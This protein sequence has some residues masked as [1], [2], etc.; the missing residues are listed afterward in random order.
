M[1]VK[2]GIN[3]LGRIGRLAFR[4]A[5][6]NPAFDIV[7]VNDPGADAETFAH[8]LNFDSVHGRWQHEATADGDTL[9][10]GER[11]IAFSRHKTIS[12]NNWR[13]CD[14]VLEASGKMKTVSVL[15]DYLEQGVKRVVV[16]APVKEPGALNIVMGVNDHLFDPAQHQIITAASCTTNCLAPVVKVLQD[17][18]GIKHASI[19]TIHDLTNTQSIL[20]APHKDLRRARACG[21]SLIPTSTGSATAIVEIF[22]ELK[23]KIDGHAVRVPLANA[24]LTDCVFEVK[25]PTSVA[26]INGWLKSAAQNELKGILGYEER[27][28]VS[29][30]YKTD[31]RSSIIDAL[32]TKVING[33]HVKIYAWYDNEWGYANRTVE[34]IEKVG[35]C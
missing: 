35:T 2:L 13:N 26:E 16:S 9:V 5:W 34:L 10:I 20:D 27:P 19:T 30:D 3:G 18:I 15:N 33:T 29:I 6:N 32:S 24:S 1:T 4:I 25:K 8:L 21:M 23:G 12:D 31:P 7:Q 28:L 14:V 17:K 11:R 22:P